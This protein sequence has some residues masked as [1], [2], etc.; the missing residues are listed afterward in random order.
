MQFNVTT[1][2]RVAAQLAGRP[3]TCES[4]LTT[5]GRSPKRQNDKADQEQGPCQLGL[6]GDQRL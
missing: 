6:D 4:R 1:A 3:Q 5:R 2:K